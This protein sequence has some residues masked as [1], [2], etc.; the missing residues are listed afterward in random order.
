MIS[1]FI[2]VYLA[3]LYGG[4]RLLST[5]D[6]KRMFLRE[7]WLQLGSVRPKD[8]SCLWRPSPS[9]LRFGAWKIQYF[10]TVE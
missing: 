1:H 7:H 8:L 9:P 6:P 10:T 5:H 2:G 4:P 3:S